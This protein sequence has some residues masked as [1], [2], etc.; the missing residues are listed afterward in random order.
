MTAARRAVL[1]GGTFDPVHLGH[2]AIAGQAREQLDADQAWLIPAR[3]PP[4][5]PAA[6]AGG[7]DR[8]ALL[9]AAAAGQP[10][11]RVLDLELRRAGPSYTSDTVAE[12]AALHPQVEQWFLLGADAA[13]E[14]RTWHRLDELLARTRFVVVNREGIGELTVDEA[15]ALGFDSARLRIILVNSPP[16]SATEVRR[17]AA[18]GLPLLDLVPAEVARLIEERGLYVEGGGDVVGDGHPADEV[19]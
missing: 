2:L 6:V 16:I 4:H 1:V 18:A 19:G 3:R 9:Q 11:L 13:R 8:L 15:A 12:L 7:A 5:R 14:I 10:W 17:R